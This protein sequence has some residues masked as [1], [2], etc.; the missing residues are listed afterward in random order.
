MPWGLEIFSVSSCWA[1]GPSKRT[2]ALGWTLSCVHLP[3]CERLWPSG[4][5]QAPGPGHHHGA[6]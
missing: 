6:G 3:V 1:Q 2:S 4:K 5:T